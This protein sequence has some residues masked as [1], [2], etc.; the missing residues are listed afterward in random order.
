MCSI[1]KILILAWMISLPTAHSASSS[2]LSSTTSKLVLP[3]TKTKH[4][5]FSKKHT[6]LTGYGSHSIRK[7]IF[8]DEKLPTI[9]TSKHRNH[10][11]LGVYRSKDGS[12]LWFQSLCKKNLNLLTPDQ[13]E[14]GNNETQNDNNI[15]R[16]VCLSVADGT[17]SAYCNQNLD[18]EIN[19]IPS[20]AW[21]PIEGLYG[22]YEVPSG[23]IA[24]LMTSSHKVYTAPSYRA[25]NK[26]NGNKSWWQIRRVQSLELV[27]LPSSVNQQSLTQRQIKEEARQLHLLRDALRHHNLYYSSSFQDDHET[28][29]QE[30]VVTDMTHTLQR[31]FDLYDFNCT[32]TTSK[33]WWDDD[34][35]GDDGATNIQRPDS[36]FFWNEP[37]L[38]V[39][40]EQHKKQKQKTPDA[41]G[42]S[43]AYQ[44]LLQ[45]VIPVTSAFV[46]VQ[47]NITLSSE[48]AKST[49]STSKSKQ[50]ELP[51]VYDE[52]LISR[53]SR[54]RAGTRFTKRGADG[55]GAVTNYAET[56]QICFL[57]SNGSTSKFTTKKKSK[58]GIDFSLQQ[59]MS[60]VQT[61]GSIPLR[62]SSPAD[63][64]TYAPKIRIGTDP[65]AQARAFRSHLVEQCLLYC[66]K[67]QNEDSSA[68]PR[69]F[70]KKQP[71]LVF[72]NLIDKKKDQGRLGKAFDAVLEAVLEVHEDDAEEGERDKVNDVS[73]RLVFPQNMVEHTW[74]DFH[75]ETKGGQWGK[76]QNLLDT[77]SP[78]LEEHGY[79]CAT[80]PSASSRGA[81][82]W[83]IVHRQNGVV[84]TNC[85]DCLDR[86]NV[87]QSI[88]G[89]FMLFRQMNEQLS[90][91]SSS[92]SRKSRSGSSAQRTMP[93]NYVSSFRRNGLSLP[94]S[95]GEVSHRLIWADNAD[96]ISR[97]YAGTPALK[98]DFTR[99]GKRTKRG[100]LDDGMNSLQRY[101]INNF[102]DADR[103]E[104]MD[105]MVGSADFTVIDDEEEEQME[106][107]DEVGETRS[108]GGGATFFNPFFG[109]LDHA[110]SMT[111]Q[112][113]T[114]SVMLGDAAELVNAKNP[115]G[116]ARRP[117][118]LRW[119][120]GDLQGHMR[121]RAAAIGDAISLLST[122]T[123]AGDYSIANHLEAI[124]RRAAHDEPWWVVE[125]D[126]SD[127][128]DDDTTTSSNAM[129][130]SQLPGNV[131]DNF[132]YGF[133][134]LVAVSKAPYATAAAVVCIFVL[135]LFPQF[136][137]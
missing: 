23:Y 59:V 17:L 80:P 110:S 108:D 128:S 33:E 31:S 40:L 47:T 109:S 98:G 35:D 125:D 113:A 62:W 50:M 131:A 105:L 29:H 43:S 124:D 123:S 18:N 103:Q 74:Y 21:I 42:I 4:A 44:I 57:C 69:F 82:K 11:S 115:M 24:V 53:R 16:T 135:G 90:T 51:L 10:P 39:L 104:G 136:Q 127:V 25:T 137:I 28:D 67:I 116:T 8:V 95:K 58:S 9:P 64:K 130:G 52:V 73:P 61:R 45:H 78:T 71:Q 88:F 75:A 20:S 134:A 120:P 22:V 93:L 111:I 3:K 96:A 133:G 7:S 117:L 81:S 12:K 2:T 121:S 118:E 72:V 26:K 48:A 101:Y 15:A 106:D 76:L 37:A 34:D 77:L 94:W 114:R 132:G 66:D 27:H 13:G 49:T 54:F 112:E 100:A 102:L 46:G 32:E 87:V 119:L 6:R 89:R 92:K 68:T 99:T 107:G 85:M 129:N 97:L 83:N 122:K 56:E 30:T 60:F 63:V 19:S 5:S 126:F 36:R 1:Y 38:K 79:F 86:T 65:L 41:E 70:P 91:S 84:R 55:T 14:I